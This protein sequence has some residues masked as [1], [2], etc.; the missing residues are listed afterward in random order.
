MTYRKSETTARSPRRRT[1]HRAALIREDGFV[2]ALCFKRPRA[3]D[4][5]RATWTIRDEAVTCP[6]CLEAINAR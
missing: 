2:S 1:Y 3:I 4:M 5:R 6:K